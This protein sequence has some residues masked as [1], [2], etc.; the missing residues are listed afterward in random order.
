[1]SISQRRPNFIYILADDL[2]YADLGCL[3]ARDAQ[4]RSA[5]ITPNVDR[6]AKQGLLFT[7][8]LCELCRVLAHTFR[9]DHGSLAVSLA[10][11]CGGAAC[12]DHQGRQ[13]ARPSARSP[14]VAVTVA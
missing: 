6:L 3:G 9:V 8:G 14:D 1:M 12:I 2:G 5:N 13:G 7:R 10:R 11:R 4:G